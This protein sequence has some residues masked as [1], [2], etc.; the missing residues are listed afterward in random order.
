MEKMNRKRFLNRQINVTLVVAES[1]VKTKAKDKSGDIG[2]SVGTTTT[3]TNSVNTKPKDKPNEQIS[4]EGANTS[5]NNT[6]SKELLLLSPNCLY[7][8]LEFPL[9][10]K[11]SATLTPS[12]QHHISEIEKKRKSEN[13]PAGSELT[14]KEKKQQKKMEKQQK[15][16][17]FNG[18]KNSEPDPQH[19]L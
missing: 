18:R 9:H 7:P 19:S 3:N 11:Q 17:E 8:S 14:R 6:F 10:P 13:S 15:K 5:D 4:S 1:P 2:V 16:I 12:V